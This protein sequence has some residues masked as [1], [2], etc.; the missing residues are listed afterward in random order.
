MTDRR[1]QVLEAA[2]ELLAEGGARALTHRAVDRRVG[3]PLGSTANYFPTRQ[4]LEAAVLEEI[5]AEDQRASQEIGVEAAFA[6]LDQA[7]EHLAKFIRMGVDGPL[8][9]ACRAAIALGMAGVDISPRQLRN[10]RDLVGWFGELGVPDPE[11]RARV[12]G[13]YM[14]GVLLRHSTWQTDGT[15]EE[16][17]RTI[18]ALLD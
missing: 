17:T 16:W 5:S 12:V 13:S 7:A 18:R 15:V 1:A 11:R 14:D 6:G 3:I 9:V 4:S 10:E 8:A 2:L